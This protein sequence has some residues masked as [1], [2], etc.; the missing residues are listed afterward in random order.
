MRYGLTTNALTSSTIAIAPTIVTI[1]SIVTRHESGRP[2]V[3][4]STGFRECRTGRGAGGGA[5]LPGGV[6]G[7]G[8]C[9]SVGSVG[10]PRSSSPPAS[11][12][13][14][15]GVVQPVGGDGGAGGELC[16]GTGAP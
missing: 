4:R 7:N 5:S 15:G 13:T 6:Y 8:Y 12:P 10:Q 11:A 2:R 1:Q 3:S 9:G 16:S 14:G